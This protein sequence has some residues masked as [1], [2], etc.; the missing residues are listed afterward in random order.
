MSLEE[1]RKC[2]AY[3][4]M[5]RL[6]ELLNAKSEE[7][8]DKLLGYVSREKLEE[9]ANEARA[10]EVPV[11]ER[12]IRRYLE[13]NAL[14][15]CKECLKEGLF[16]EARKLIEEYKL[17]EEMQ[18]KVDEKEYEWCMERGMHFKAADVAR[19]GNLGEDKLLL[20]EAL[21]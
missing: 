13:K 12:I 7:E 15:W 2:E 8:R 1:L 5:K 9:L 17:G 3:E 14:K 19:K 21:L 18:K 16:D 4:R 10:N 6:G 20:A 11:L